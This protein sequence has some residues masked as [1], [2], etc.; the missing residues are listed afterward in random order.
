MYEGGILLKDTTFSGPWTSPTEHILLLHNT[1]PDTE[2][3]VTLTDGTNTSTGSVRTPMP[4]IPLSFQRSAIDPQVLEVYVCNAWPG[5]PAEAA[6]IEYKTGR[7]EWQKLMDITA[8]QPECAM[9]PPYR[10][11]PTLPRGRYEMRLV[12]KPAGLPVFNMVGLVGV[13]KS[14]VIYQVR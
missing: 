2:Y 6:W 11:T 5:W 14:D 4:I 1:L 7:G 8:R 10:F 13:K 12:A 9:Q 3:S